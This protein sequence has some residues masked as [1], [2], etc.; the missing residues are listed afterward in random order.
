MTLGGRWQQ[1]VG[2]LARTAALRISV[3]VLAGAALAFIAGH[4]L[5]SLL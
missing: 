2:S 1:I 5:Q 4:F 3:G